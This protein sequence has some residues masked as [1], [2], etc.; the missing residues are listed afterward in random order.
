MR[1]AATGLALLVLAG[2]GG[3][4]PP[5]A[6]TQQRLPRTLAQA[7]AQQADAIARTAAASDG[8]RAQ[9]LAAG[10]RDDVIAAVGSVPARYRTTLL[11]AVND[12]A[13]RIACVPAAQTKPKPP[14]PPD[15][16]PPGHG[17]HGK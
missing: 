6:T 4:S 11:A 8:C 14:K 3:G 16:K 2:C 7:W 1:L 10:L 13:D 12:L 15:H 17:K 5:S 9:Q